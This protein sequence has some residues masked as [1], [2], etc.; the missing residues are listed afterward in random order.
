MK[1][2]GRDEEARAAWKRAAS[3]PESRDTEV[4]R[5]RKAAIEALKP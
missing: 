1:A 4:E 2:L 5:A 3:D